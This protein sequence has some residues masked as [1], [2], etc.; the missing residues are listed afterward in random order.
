MAN[1]VCV[2]E[3]PTRGE[4][5]IYRMR[6][7]VAPN[8]F[9][10]VVPLLKFLTP[11]ENCLPPSGPY[12]D[13]FVLEKKFG[14]QTFEVY[15]DGELATCIVCW[16]PKHGEGHKGCR[17]KCRVCET[18]RHPGR[19]CPQIYVRMGWWK[20]RGHTPSPRVHLRPNV[21]ALAYLVKAGCLFS[22]SKVIQPIR[23]NMNHP[24][25]KEF[26]QGKPQPQYTPGP[27]TWPP[28]MIDTKRQELQKG[29]TN[30]GAPQGGI[31]TPYR[32]STVPDMIGTLVKHSI[33]GDTHH[34]PTNDRQVPEPTTSASGPTIA[35]L[36]AKVEEQAGKIGRLMKELDNAREALVEKSAAL[37]EKDARI[38][39]LE[40]TA[41][42]PGR[43]RVRFEN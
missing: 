15:K 43:K 37:A 28:S 40:D 13:E 24:L 29:Q 8:V 2:D 21:R 32:A 12:F 34:S 38:A 3:L 30:S 25:V 39:E 22:I 42:K 5:E 9:H 26:Y 36:S 20:T 10:S 7:E 27:I 16:G 14:K 31:S 35:E 19:T 4:L 17:E 1:P 11:I 23:A 18:Q 41:G 6:I 33:H